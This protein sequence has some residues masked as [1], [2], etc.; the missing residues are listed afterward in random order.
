MLPAKYTFQL[1]TMRGNGG[2]STQLLCCIG[3]S[4]A[5]DMCNNIIV[6]G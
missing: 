6:D 5:L 2:K 3:T 4:I 1:I